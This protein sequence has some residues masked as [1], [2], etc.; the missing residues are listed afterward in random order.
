MDEEAT[1]PPE[2]SQVISKLKSL[3]AKLQQIDAIRGCT[4]GFP[5]GTNMLLEDRR[6]ERER[7]LAEDGY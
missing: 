7:E 4:A 5:S 1:I 2:Q 6:Q 3:E